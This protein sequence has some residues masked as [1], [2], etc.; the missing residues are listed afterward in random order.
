MKTRITLLALILTLTTMS[1]LARPGHG[2]FR[3]IDRVREEL[4]LSDNQVAQIK[5]IFAELREQ[6]REYRESMRGGFGDVAEALLANPND[7]AAAQKLIEEREAARSAMKANRLNAMS[8]ALNVLT[9]EQRA[10]LSEIVAKR[11]ERRERRR[12]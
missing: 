10:K 12:R 1:A 11:A 7:L 5:V 6:N 9:A 8:K 3:N 4:N 2:M